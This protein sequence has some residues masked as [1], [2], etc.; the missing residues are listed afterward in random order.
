MPPAPCSAPEITSASSKGTDTLASFWHQDYSRAQNSCGAQESG[1]L[2]HVQECGTF[3]FKHK[4]CTRIQL[5]VFSC[6]SVEILVVCSAALMTILVHELAILMNRHRNLVL[7]GSVNFAFHH[8]FCFCMV[9]Y[10][11]ASETKKLNILTTTIL[12]LVWSYCN[13]QNFLKISNHF[14]SL[15]TANLSLIS[16]GKASNLCRTICGGLGSDYRRWVLQE[17][18]KMHLTPW[19]SSVLPKLLFL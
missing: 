15:V 9:H 14:W 5:I 17:D 1:V 6:T 3:G 4:L 2:G 10:N 18:C 8:P 12:G 19:I 13:H 7:I 11:S 16:R